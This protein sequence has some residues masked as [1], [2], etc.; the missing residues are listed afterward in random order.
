MTI[1]EDLG[2][3]IFCMDLDF[4]HK[5]SNFLA[6]H[7]EDAG[8]EIICLTFSWHISLKPKSKDAKPFP[9]NVFLP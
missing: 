1:K 2:D 9:F 3:L 8:S 6:F 7:C 5:L 4:Q